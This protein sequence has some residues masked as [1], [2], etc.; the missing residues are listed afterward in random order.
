MVREW[1]AIGLA[2]FALTFTLGH[3]TGCRPTDAPRENVR[4]IVLTVARAVKD[5]DLLCETAAS[6][7]KNLDVLKKCGDAYDAAREALI[8]AEDLLDAWDDAAAARVP[9]VVKTAVGKLGEIARAIMKG[10]DKIPPIVD[11]AARLSELYTGLC[12]G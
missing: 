3:C 6:R 10:G 11:D 7:Q 4:A 12:H 1:I 9:C 5:A 8:Q 2:L